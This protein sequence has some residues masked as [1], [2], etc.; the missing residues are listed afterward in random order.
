MFRQNFRLYKKVH[1]WVRSLAL[2]QSNAASAQIRRGGGWGRRRSRI[3]FVCDEICSTSW[4]SLWKAGK[5]VTEIRILS[6]KIFCKLWR[7]LVRTLPW[8]LAWSSWGK[9]E[10]FP[11]AVWPELQSC[12]IACVVDEVLWPDPE[13]ADSHSLYKLFFSYCFW[14][15]FQR[16]G[17]SI[18]LS[19][20]CGAR[21]VI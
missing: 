6:S 5:Y 7:R 15:I 2:N 3:M 19:V 17:F 21:K 12:N 1:R 18:S 11:P 13:D 9:Q 14:L 8:S 16:N 20:F 4:S 10:A